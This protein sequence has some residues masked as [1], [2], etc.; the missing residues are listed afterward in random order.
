MS[1]RQERQHHARRICQTITAKI[2]EISLRGLGHWPQTWELVEEASDRFLDELDAW[3]ET[4]TPEGR[5]AV[6]RA[7][8]K[9]L[10][11]WREA[12]ALF[13]LLEGAPSEEPAGHAHV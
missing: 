9:L 13:A 5:E 10:V 12:G 6:K 4:D 11:A 7:A 3:V 8:E 1:T 2:G